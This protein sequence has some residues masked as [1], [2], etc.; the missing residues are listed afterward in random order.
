MAVFVTE[1]DNRNRGEYRIEV[2]MGNRFERFE[3]LMDVNKWLDL[4]KKSGGIDELLVTLRQIVLTARK[5][6]KT[7]SCYAY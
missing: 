2:R 4:M 5:E 3:S 1:T 7:E 6:W